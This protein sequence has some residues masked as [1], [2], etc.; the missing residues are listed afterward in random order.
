MDIYSSNLVKILPITEHSTISSFSSLAMIHMA[1]ISNFLYKEHM[2][3]EP[4][5]TVSP[6]I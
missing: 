3:T 1:T 6:I 4:S 2:A 5:L